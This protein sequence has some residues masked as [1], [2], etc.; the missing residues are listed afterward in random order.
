MNQV[1]KCGLDTAVLLVQLELAKDNMEGDVWAQSNIER[2]DFAISAVED[3]CGA[4]V[5]DA[6]GK[7]DQ[8]MNYYN[9][10]DYLRARAAL[11]SAR[12]IVIG[13]LSNCATDRRPLITINP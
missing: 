5:T 11:D 13:A 7:I 8:A 9:E 4:F 3:A 12:D 2:L 10:K 1:C 6:R